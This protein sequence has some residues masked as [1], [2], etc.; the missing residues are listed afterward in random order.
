MDIYFKPEFIYDKG[1]NGGRHE[2]SVS[3][4]VEITSISIVD[5]ESEME[6]PLTQRQIDE[7]MKY[8]R[9]AIEETALDMA[10][11]PENY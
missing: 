10:K 8:H 5:T 3:E 11:N 7:V 1:S 4:S 9:N 2:P 6:F